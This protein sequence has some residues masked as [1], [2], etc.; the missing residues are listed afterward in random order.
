MAEV[1][2]A[3]QTLQDM[4]YLAAVDGL[5]L[6]KSSFMLLQ[7]G[8]ALPYTTGDLWQVIDAIPPKALTT[9]LSLGSLNSFYQDY[10]G[11]FSAVIA[12]MSDDFKRVMG[13][14]LSEWMDYKK[15]VTPKELKEADG[16]PGLFEFW[17]GQNLPDNVATTAISVFNK[18]THNIVNVASKKYYTNSDADHPFDPKKDTLY[19]IKID[20]IVGGAIA[21]GPK[22]EV[23]V[24]SKTSSS[25][26]STT[27]AKGGVSGFFDIFSLGG[28]GGYS[29]TTSKFTS[30]EV[31]IDATFQHVVT[32]QTF[33]PGDWYNSSFLNY[34]YKGE[35]AWSTGNPI[36]WANTFGPD[37]NL[38]R[39]IEGLIIVDGIDIVMTSDATYSAE[40]QKE[41]NAQAKGGV[42]PFFSVNASG[43]Y[44]SKVSFNDQGK[45]TVKT[46]CTV[47]NPAIFGANVRAVSAYVSALALQ[48]SAMAK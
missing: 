35:N 37:G 3:V 4:W 20:D 28:S 31:T 24:D 47:G 39:I 11:L 46:S 44:S 33:K 17:A 19:N 9:V 13:D 15:K 42:W 32:V 29:K 30:S 26:V 40:E 16:W 38:Q 22:K 14:Y 10:G 43:G 45:M 2:K 5:G 12:P 41:I 8:V 18:D 23:H 1:N 25:D 34:A 7:P 36:T 48:A 6:D 21:H 27:W